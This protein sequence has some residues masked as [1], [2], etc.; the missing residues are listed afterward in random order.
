MRLRLQL[1]ALEAA[2]LPS[3]MNLPGWRWH[4]LK[5]AMTGRWSVTVNGNWRLTYA[6]E[7]GDAILVDYEDYH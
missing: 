6:F 7:N 4:A 1:G 3:D 2:K 5:G